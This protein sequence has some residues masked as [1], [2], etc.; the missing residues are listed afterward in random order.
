M[1]TRAY[2]VRG[3]SRAMGTIIKLVLW[4]TPLGLIVVLAANLL[5][6]LHSRSRIHDT[7]TTLPEAEAAVVLGTSPSS[8][9][10]SGRIEGAV[11]LFQ[12]GKVS[13]ILVTGDSHGRYY[14]E[15]HPM[16]DMLLAAGIPEAAI[17]VDPYGL[18]T[19]DSLA[20]ARNVFGL[21]RVILVSQR[22]HNYRAVYLAQ[23]YGLQAQAYN[24][25]GSPPPHWYFTRLREYAARAMAVVDVHVLDRQPEYEDQVPLAQS[26]P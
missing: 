24:A 13:R 10:M 8:E 23:A 4:L 11:E 12:A 14:D 22:F 3:R 26:A 16:R 6:Y 20:R 15:V 5:V 25:P 18:R 17:L 9:Y 1:S 7:L 19:L 2:R 21:E